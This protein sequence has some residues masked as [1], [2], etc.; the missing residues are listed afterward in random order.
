[1]SARRLM[2]ACILLGACTTPV[3]AGEQKQAG[4]GNA[5]FSVTAVSKG[6]SR[7]EEARARKKKGDEYAAQDDSKRAAD[8]YIQALSVDTAAFTVE[9]RLRMAIVVSWADRLEDASRILRAILAEDRENREARAQLAQFLSWSGKLDEA[10]VEADTVLSRYPDDREALLVKANVLRWRG[11]AGASIPLYERVLAKG[12]SFEARLGLAYAYLD[13]GMEEKA[14][15]IGRTLMPVF[16]AQRKE[17]A[18]LQKRLSAVS[19]HEHRQGG[20]GPAVSSEKSADAVQ[21]KTEE[22]HDRKKR[23]DEYAGQDDNKRAADEYIQALSLDASAFTEEERLRMATVISWAGRR[24]ESIGALRAILEGDPSNN[25]AL[26]Y[27]AKVLSWSGK[28]NEAQSAVD[29]VLKAEPDDREALLVKANIVRWRGEASASIPLYERVLAKG[30]SFDARLGLAYAYLDAGKKDKAQEIGKTL[31]PVS[32]D[33]R[34]ELTTFS[35]ALSAAT[36]SPIG[37]QAGYYRDS[38][39]NTVK[40]SGLVYG[41]WARNWE[42]EL[43]YWLI[44]ANDPER[45]EWAETISITA[46]RHESRLSTAVRAGISSTAGGTRNDLVGQAIADIDRGWWAVS[47]NASRDVL[48]DTAELIQNRIKR[49]AGTVTLSETASPRWTFTESY[50]RASY[51]DSNDLDDLGAG[52]RYTV[53][54]APA[55][56]A[57]GYRFRY[58]NFRRQ[59]GSGYFDPED[60]ISHQIYVSLYAEREGLYASLEPYTG[61]Q[62]FKRY[63]ETSGNYFAGYAASAGWTRKKNTSGELTAEGGN[64]AVGSTAGFNYYQVG[65]RLVV[66]F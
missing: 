21:R 27:L 24:E 3:F 36:A 23:G 1:M 9:E 40:R 39:D 35:E 12:E 7:A 53:V 33:Q 14:Q 2:I 32:A 38:D 62:S 19:P 63:G 65:F 5:A 52:V 34:K 60:F 61:Y 50:T 29:T 47:V 37:L 54:T 58:W 11:G 41:F 20:S 13:T 10:Q 15:E 25:K 18:K 44:E 28:L 16:E 45:H 64:Y 56:I 42:A 51:S 17:L 66:N 4:T 46:R 55:K 48:S 59:S 30:E 49:T 8:E 43:V 31:S 26:L 57:T 6:K 22:A